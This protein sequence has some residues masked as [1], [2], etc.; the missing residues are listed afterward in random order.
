[1]GLI[2]LNYLIVYIFVPCLFEVKKNSVCVCV[3]VWRGEGGGTA[4]R[5]GK[6]VSFPYFV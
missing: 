5:G 4:G 1:M 3:Y 6:V 2:Q